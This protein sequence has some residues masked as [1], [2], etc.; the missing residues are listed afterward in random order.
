[1]DHHKLRK[2][3]A[4]SKTWYINAPSGKKQSGNLG[5]I[6]HVKNILK[7]LN[8]VMSIKTIPTTLYEIFCKSIIH[9]LVL[10]KIIKDPDDKISRVCL[11]H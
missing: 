8:R 7:M 1:M 6:F 5:K 9:F 11:K 10:V 4:M 3:I 2:A